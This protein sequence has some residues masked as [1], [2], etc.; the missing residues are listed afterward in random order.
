[1]ETISRARP[2]AR[3]EVL[4][5]YVRR[6]EKLETIAA[7]IEGVDA[8]YAIQAGQEVRV[9]ANCDLLS[10]ED[11]EKL[12]AKIAERLEETMTYPGQVKVTVIREVRAVDFAR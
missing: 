1:A 5:N 4:E 11:T 12:A 9:V 10:D 7:D 8:V 2:G 3:R 6:L